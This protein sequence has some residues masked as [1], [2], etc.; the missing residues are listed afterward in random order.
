[1]RYHDFFVERIRPG[2]RVLDLGCGYAAVAMSIA[3]R[4]G[5]DVTGMDWSESNLEQARRTVAARSLSD[6]LHLIQGDI[7]RDRA[8]GR[9]DVIVLSNVLEHLADREA[10]LA[11]YREW[12]GARLLLVRVPAIDRD[13]K[14]AWKRDLG[15]DYRCDDTH[16][17]EYTED[18]LRRELAAAG[19]R[20]D[21]MIAR[22]GEYWTAARPA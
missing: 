12:Y 10:L 15:L 9:F 14:T 5:A 16:E 8:P 18:Q 22:W 21:E 6:R 4:S 3:E 2:Q 11:R 17:T 7:T 1:M 19:W 20:A 13:W